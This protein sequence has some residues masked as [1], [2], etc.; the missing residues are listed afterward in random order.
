MPR[1]E[2]GI[3]GYKKDPKNPILFSFNV[4]HGEEMPSDS[5]DSDYVPD[6][7]DLDEPG[8]STT[9]S[10]KR[11]SLTKKA[12]SERTAKKSKNTN[13]KEQK[14]R[15]VPYNGREVKL[16][17][18]IWLK[19]FHLVIAKDGALPFLMRASKVCRLWKDISVNPKLWIKVDFSFGW[20]K[21]NVKLFKS[22]CAERLT[23]CTHLNLTSCKVTSDMGTIQAIATHCINLQSLNLS[24]CQKLKAESVSTIV[25]G[26]RQLQDIDLTYTTPEAVSSQSL[27]HVVDKCGSNLRRLVVTENQLKGFGLVL[28]NLMEK[29]PNLEHLDASSC[30]LSTTL[31]LDIERFQAACP[32]LKVLGLANTPFRASTATHRAQDE[33]PGF[34]N[35]EEISLAS[36]DM[37]SSVTDEVVQRLLKSA[38]NLRLLDLRGCKNGP[39]ISCLEHI[40]AVNLEQLYLSRSAV[41]TCHNLHNILLKWRHSLTDLDLSWNYFRDGILELGLICLKQTGVALPCKLLNVNL[42]G[43]SITMTMVRNLLS[44]VPSLQSLDLTSC[45]DVSRGCKREYTTK[46]ELKQLQDSSD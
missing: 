12:S 38:D 26:C 1:Q 15:V 10:K 14:E 6:K 32:K 33:S 9:V 4:P 46:R 7:S 31:T 20:Q 22:L 5:D 18:E 8:T 27:C 42:A 23:E 19:I 11:K 24:R 43:T 35:L 17:P 30:K 13:A 36:L 2:R 21:L 37:G 29:C 28:N 45:R 16:P 39:A 44:N 40:S 34:A 3:F 25:N 41:S